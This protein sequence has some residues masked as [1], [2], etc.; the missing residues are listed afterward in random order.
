MH[1]A[2]GASIE[3]PEIPDFTERPERPRREY[4]DRDGG[5]HERGGARRSRATGPPRSC[6]SA[7]GRKGGIRPA[8]LVGAIANESGLIGRDI[9]PIRITEHSSVVGVPQA[10]LDRV[11]DSMTN[12]VVRGKKVVGAPV[13]RAQRRRVARPRRLARTAAAARVGGPSEK[14]LAAASVRAGRTATS[15]AATYGGDRP[16]RNFGPKPGGGPR[17]SGRPKQG[18]KGH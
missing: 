4:G 6:T 5:R 10:S 11:I 8:D 1:E 3:E 16:A 17:P 18:G 9:G 13:H 15:R 2:S 7:I 12:A 14:G